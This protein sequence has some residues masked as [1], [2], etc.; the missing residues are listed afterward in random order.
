M[1]VVYRITYPNG[2]IYIGQDRTDSLN[3]FGSASSRLIEE[4]FDEAERRDFTIRK[5]ILWYSPNASQAEVTRVEVEFIRRERS[6]DP[7]VGYNKWPTRGEPPAR[8]SGVEPRSAH[9]TSAQ[10]ETWILAALDAGKP[11]TLEEIRGSLWSFYAREAYEPSEALRVGHLISG[12]LS[13]LKKRGRVAHLHHRW[14]IRRKSTRPPVE[15]STPVGP[16]KQEAMPI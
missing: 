3:Y 15:T 16:G 2:K 5:E 7:R 6:N 10:V 13:R 1:P 4:D 8:P 12:T 11:M 9:V 14:S